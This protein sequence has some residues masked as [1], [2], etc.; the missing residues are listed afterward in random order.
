MLKVLKKLYRPEDFKA[1][2]DKQVK[3]AKFLDEL[4]NDKIS[5]LSDDI[6]D[7]R[8][9]EYDK[10]RYDLNDDFKNDN[11]FNNLQLPKYDVENENPKAIRKEMMD[12]EEEDEELIR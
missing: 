10:L 5:Q 3:N 12:D 7:F 8:E 11:F 9:D 2:L 4:F 1:D 6:K